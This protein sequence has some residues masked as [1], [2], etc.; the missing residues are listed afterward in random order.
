VD[1]SCSHHRGRKQLLEL[2]TL[3]LRVAPLQCFLLQVVVEA[4]KRHCPMRLALVL[5]QVLLTTVFQQNKKA[6]GVYGHAW[7]TAH[8]THTPRQQSLR[9]AQRK[10]YSLSEYQGHTYLPAECSQC[11]SRMR[12]AGGVR[13]VGA[14]MLITGRERRGCSGKRGGGRG[15]CACDVQRR[16]RL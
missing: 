3:L 14:G 6:D 10:C 1:A 15:C 5:L 9:A 16:Q 13:R 11:L 8:S 7:S 2:G 12:S 4:V